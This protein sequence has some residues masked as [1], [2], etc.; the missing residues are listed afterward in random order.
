MKRKPLLIGLTAL[1]VALNLGAGCPN[2]VPGPGGGNPGLAGVWTLTRGAVKVTFTYSGTQNGE[3]QSQTTTGSLEPLDPADFPAYLGDLVAQW[4]A[5]L[6]D[7]NQKLDE[8]LPE[9]VIVTFPSLLSMKIVNAA[10]TTKQGEGLYSPGDHKYLF[11]G[12]L[13]GG[14]QG[15]DQGAGGVLTIATIDGQFNASA[16]TTSGKLARTLAVVLIVP[17]SGLIV[18]AQVSVDFTGTRT[19]D[20]PTTP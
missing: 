5:G 16:L 4:N 17:N 18:A 1:A 15:S 7:L 9:Q 10:D 2:G 13:S 6:T 11:A 19:G 8:A 3:T 12:D 20:V 14:G